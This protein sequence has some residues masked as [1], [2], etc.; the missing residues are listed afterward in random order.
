MRFATFI[1]VLLCCT[2]IGSAQ[3]RKDYT[4]VL[5]P[6]AMLETPGAYGS[7]WTSDAWVVNSS[8]SAVIVPARNC[9]VAPCLRVIPA[10]ASETAPIEPAPLGSTESPT[11]IVYVP[12]AQID[13]LHFNLRIR[14]LSRQA[15]TAGTEIPIVYESEFRSKPIVLP[16][17]PID[18]RFRSSLRIY[19]LDARYFTDPSSARVK[20]TISGETELKTIEANLR[21]V[22][23]SAGEAFHVL[24]GYFQILD[25]SAVIPGAPAAVDITIE[26]ISP[27]LRIWAFSSVTNNET[28]HVTTVT[29]QL[30]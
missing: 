9:H 17:V 3:E 26:P 5:F 19:D 30:H 24:T 14:D 8:D 21:V 20:I 23:G 10:K 11:F 28:Q 27:G 22:A 6:I 2:S 18:S 16:N 4:A 29:P 1:L 12:T 25:L 13:A 7:L 15:L